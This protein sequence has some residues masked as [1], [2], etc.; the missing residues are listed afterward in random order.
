MNTH[1]MLLA[2]VVLIVGTVHS[3]QARTKLSKA[4]VQKLF[5][6]KPWR[7]PKGIFHFRS[8]GTVTYTQKFLTSSK[9]HGPWPYQL[10]SDGAIRSKTTRYRFY[11]TKNGGYEYYHT[12]SGR[13]FKARLH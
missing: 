2:A 12:R 13:Y 4:E 7:G 8:N 10:L 5:I 9:K 11:R 6:G 1:R 3:A